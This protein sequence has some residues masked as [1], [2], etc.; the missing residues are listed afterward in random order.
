MFRPP[1]PTNW[2]KMT[3]VLQCILFA[4]LLMLATKLSSG[5]TSTASYEEMLQAVKSGSFTLDKA[6]KSKGT[7]EDILKE[8]LEK[9]EF[10]FVLLHIISLSSRY[11]GEILG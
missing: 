1:V 11:I 6:V 8:L 3:K 9:S 5:A 10:Y 4:V 7:S 2:P